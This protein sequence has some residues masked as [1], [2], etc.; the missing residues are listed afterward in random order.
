M[1]AYEE[2]LE[3]D[4]NGFLPLQPTFVTAN[5]EFAQIIP[6]E[7]IAEWFE[8]H[9]DVTGLPEEVKALKGI[10]ADDNPVV[11]LMK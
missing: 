7:T 6:A 9:P 2:G 5:G 1:A 10:T 4:L 3:N 8:E 11:V